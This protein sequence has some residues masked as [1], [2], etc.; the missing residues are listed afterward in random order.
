MRDIGVPRQPLP[1]VPVRKAGRAGR[2]Q[3][4]TGLFDGVR[5]SGGVRHPDAVEL[6]KHPGDL[7]PVPADHPG[8][9]KVEG[10]RPLPL[11]RR[12]PA[13][14]LQ[15]LKL[16]GGVAFAQKTGVIAGQRQRPPVEMLDSPDA[17]RFGGAQRTGHKYGGNAKQYL[18]FFDTFS[19]NAING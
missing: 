8:G 19:F 4:V 2:I 3:P 5:A 10:E 17:A 15:R 9:G 7:R 14:L 12:P 13:E 16:L 11:R 1:A 6:L 18:H